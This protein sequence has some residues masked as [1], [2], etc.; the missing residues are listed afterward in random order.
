[1]LHIATM[2]IR[3]M[4]I[5]YAL[6]SATLLG[7]YDVAKK[8][9]VQRNSVLAVLFCATA[10]TA[11]FLL[12]FIT[13][14]AWPD[15]LKLMFKAVLVT[16]SWVSGLIGIKLLPLTTASTI[17]GARPVFVVLFSI[18]LFGERLNAFQWLGVAIAI[19]AL[20][21]LSGTSKKEGIDFSSNKGVI[22]MGI[23]VLAG[24]VSAL[25]DKYI[26]ASLEP[27]FV[28]S[29][30]NIYITALLGLII[31]VKRLKS[32]QTGQKFSWDWT[33]LLIAVLITISDFIYFTSLKEPDAMLSIISVIRRGSVIVS[34]LVGAWLFKEH[35]LK[36][37][38]LVMVLMFAGIALLTFGSC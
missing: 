26:M 5:W 30:T 12:P 22:A 20:W 9:A 24:V 2:G 1:M 34:F 29:W 36:E 32:G 18:I 23:S 8:K 35:R 37:K 28:Q 21:L 15:H 17:K 10:L 13:P 11:L 3:N 19:F 27:M 25:Y 16:T 14:G 7:V 31:I 38:A 33:L 4:W 6:I